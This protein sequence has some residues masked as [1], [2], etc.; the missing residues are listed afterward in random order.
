MLRAA[1]LFTKHR[2]ILRDKGGRSYSLYAHRVRTCEE[3]DPSP[4]S[5]LTHKYL[6]DY[7]YP[8][9]QNNPQQEST[10]DQ[11]GGKLIG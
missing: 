7:Q 10:R 4:P 9:S 5:R 6:G 11:L 2:W 3:Q 1:G 8:P